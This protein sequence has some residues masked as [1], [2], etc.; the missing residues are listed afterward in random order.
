MV[1]EK[2]V[3]DHVICESR[4]EKEFAQNLDNDSDVRLFFKLPRSFKITIPIGSYTSDWAVFLERDGEQKL[5]FVLE[6][7]GTNSDFDLR[8]KEMLKIKCGKA[9]FTALETGVVFNEAL[10]MSWRDSKRGGWW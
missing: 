5:Y 7:K 9:H 2:S 3:Y 10:V 8:L 4:I 1:N 6:T